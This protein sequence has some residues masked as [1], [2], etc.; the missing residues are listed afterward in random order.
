MNAKYV[1]ALA[2]SRLFLVAALDSYIK[3]REKKLWAWVGILPYS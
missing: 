2:A 3:S 1:N